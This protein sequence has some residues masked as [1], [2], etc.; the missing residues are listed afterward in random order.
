MAFRLLSSSKWGNK[1]QF[2]VEKGRRRE[3]ERR[4]RQTGEVP[5]SVEKVAL[6]TR[7]DV[8]CVKYDMIGCVRFVFI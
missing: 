6:N 3:R 2:K 7:L 5:Q 4:E 8:L 1:G